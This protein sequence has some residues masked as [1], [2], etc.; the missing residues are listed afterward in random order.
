MQN[1]GEILNLVKNEMNSLENNI[2]SGYDELTKFLKLPSK[3]IRPLIS[4]LYLNALGK[5][6]NKTQIKYQT[7]IELVHNAS[8][9]HDDVIDESETRRGGNSLN[10]DLGNKMAVISGDYL[11][12]LALEKVTSIGS[13]KLI[14]MFCNTLKNM[15][16]G[17]INQNLS[18][19]KITSIEEYIEKTEY[20]TA[21]LFDLSLKGSLKIAKLN[22]DNDFAKNFGIA[23]Q[24]KNDLTNYKTSKTDIKDGIYTAPVIFSG[25]V[26]ISQYGLEKTRDLLNNYVE[27]AEKSIEFMKESVYKEALLNLVRGLQNE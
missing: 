18:R 10:K 9:I 14:N 5:N 21:Q 26:E 1:Y 11:L 16:I 2:V 4:F 8:L 13:T 23:F 12:S 22:I 27:K 7:A 20:K 3:H 17:E 15:T 25:G 24:I 6:I 19:F